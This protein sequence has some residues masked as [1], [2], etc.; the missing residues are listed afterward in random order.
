MDMSSVLKKLVFTL[1]FLFSACVNPVFAALSDAPVRPPITLAEN[2]KDSDFRLQTDEV[3]Q[4]IEFLYFYLPEGIYKGQIDN[5]A[6]CEIE[7][8]PHRTRFE[9]LNIQIKLS[10]GRGS[11]KAILRFRLNTF[12]A[13]EIALVDQYEKRL[14]I[15][16]VTNGMDRR[17]ANQL[18]YTHMSFS[19]DEN[20]KVTRVY[21]FE[22]SR[23][24]QALSHASCKILSQEPLPE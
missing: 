1:P 5:G 11:Q 19:L 6:A 23:V 14:S 13:L 22:E 12:S 9:D 16:T 10:E 20:Q 21:I 15:V 18:L 2:P 3:R 7:V 8:A 24:D 17:S 4:A